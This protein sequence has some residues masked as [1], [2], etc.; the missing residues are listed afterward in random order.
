MHGEMGQWGTMSVLVRPTIIPNFTQ[1]YGQKLKW[2]KANAKRHT[3]LFKNLDLL[4]MI[5]RSSY[6]TPSREWTLVLLLYVYTF[7]LQIF[8]F[9]KS[10]ILGV[11]LVA[12]HEFGIYFLK[13]STLGPLGLKFPKIDF[14]KKTRFM[15][16]SGV[17]ITNMTFVF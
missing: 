7:F 4:K 17:L 12:E 9:F 15:G 13:F 11:I 3:F 14:A 6:S 5:R 16:F 10:A 2:L 1:L 8:N